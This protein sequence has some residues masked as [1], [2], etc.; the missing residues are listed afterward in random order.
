MIYTSLEIQV[1]RFSHYHPNITTREQRP[2]TNQPTSQVSHSTIQ[3]TTTTTTTYANHSLPTQSTSIKMCCSN[4]R[5][6]QRAPVLVTL[7]KLAYDKYQERQAVK[8]LENPSF[9]TSITRSPSPEV[10]EQ[11]A[12]AEILEKAGIIHRHTTM[13]FSTETSI[14]TSMSTRRTSANRM[15]ASRA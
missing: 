5:R 2:P 3:T 6:Q 13:H 15:M 10:I 12:N 9:Q 4:R 7:G 14:L 8:A 11:N 1:V